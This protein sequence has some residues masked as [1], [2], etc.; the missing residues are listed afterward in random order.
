M[1]NMSDEAL[2]RFWSSRD[3][4]EPLDRKAS[5]THV[6]VIDEVRMCVLT[7]VGVEHAAQE[8]DPTISRV[9]YDM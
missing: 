9:R 8:I 2:Q 1:L 3:S 7:D 4:A 5:R 6:A